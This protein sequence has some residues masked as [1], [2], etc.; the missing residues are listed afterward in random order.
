M[1]IP[2]ILEKE[3]GDILEKINKINGFVPHFQVDVVDKELFNGETYMGIEYL[4]EV[5]LRSTVELDLMVK[6]PMK[7]LDSKLKNVTKIM[8]N[9]SG[10]N[11]SDFLSISGVM[12]YIKGISINTDNTLEQYHSFIDNV[13]F[14]QFMG[15][16][17]GGQG[18]GFDNKV[19][20]N[21]RIFVEEFPD[22]PIQVDGGIKMKNVQ[23]L[24]GAG[25]NSLV[26]GSAIFNNED[27]V[28]EYNNFK[29][30]LNK[31]DR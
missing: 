13:D 31:N 1:I 5:E 27:P 25:V 12:G 7:Y 10:E 14:V 30:E 3:K 23:E 2:T 29:Q 11:I 28:K 18:R 19:L 21:I 20:D 9:I 22:I 4:K 17:S 8:A 15:V 6:N 16:I 24:L 26:I